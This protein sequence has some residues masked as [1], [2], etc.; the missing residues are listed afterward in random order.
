[1]SG[2]GWLEKAIEV[3]RSVRGEQEDKVS[4][5]VEGQRS[6]STEQTRSE[7]QRQN[8]LWKNDAPRN[9]TEVHNTTN[10][11]ERREKNEERGEVDTSK[12]KIN[13]KSQA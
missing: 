12:K 1:M 11:R 4:V 10:K 8:E 7:S 5:R 13:K 6:V 2:W 9:T 3:E